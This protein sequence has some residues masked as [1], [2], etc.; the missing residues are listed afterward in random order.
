MA[1]LPA[2]TLGEHVIMSRI[3]QLFLWNSI[4]LETGSGTSVL[5]KSS[6]AWPQEGE[7]RENVWDA[8]H[9]QG[10]CSYFFCVHG[11]YDTVCIVLHEFPKLTCCS[12]VLL[13]AMFML[14]YVSALFFL[15]RLNRNLPRSISAYRKVEH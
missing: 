9:P 14:H 1:C 15:Q 5:D 11:G 10:E 6:H 4:C 12:V 13:Q 7:A 2:C 8:G 3:A